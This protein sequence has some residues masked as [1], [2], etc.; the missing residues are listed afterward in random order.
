MAKRFISPNWRALRKLS[1]ELQR[2]FFYCWD[3]ADAA[4]VYEMDIEYM[5][6]DLG[7]HLS[8]DELL[9]LPGA[10]KISATKFLFTDFIIVNY[11]GLLK[12]GYNPHKP[13][14]RAIDQHGAENF[15]DLEIKIESGSKEEKKIQAIKIFFKLENKKIKLEEEDEDKEEDEGEDMEGVKGEGNT[16]LVHELLT[17]FKTHFPEYPVEQAED[18][19]PCLALAYKIGKTLSLTKY[20]V[21]NGSGNLVKKRWGEILEVIS[22]DK[23]YS[24]KSISFLNKDFQNLIQT[25]EASKKNGSHKQTFNGGKESKSGT[26]KDRL[27]AARRF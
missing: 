18:F 1:P 2:C 21:L 10:K 13:V 16:G 19:P 15:S 24:S 14:F 4:G 25:V 9:K 5:E 11:G 3:Q 26:S 6:V 23:W 7:F 8:F 22:S 17:E 20:Q 12:H 27:E